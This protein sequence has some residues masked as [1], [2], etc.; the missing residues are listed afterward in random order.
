MN[1]AAAL[2]SDTTGPGWRWLMGCGFVVLLAHFLLLQVGMDF[3]PGS[4]AP[5]VVKLNSRLIEAAPLRSAAQSAQSSYKVPQKQAVRAPVSPPPA[6]NPNAATSTAF[7]KSEDAQAS[8]NSLTN[9]PAP[10][11]QAEPTPTPTK[12]AASTPVQTALAR[13]PASGTLR[14]DVIVTKNGAPNTAKGEL[15]FENTGSEY[16]A[17]LETGNWFGKRVDSSRGRL[18]QQGLVPQRYSQKTG[19]EKAAHFLWAEDRISYS[20]NRPS[21]PLAAGAQD[22]LSVIIQLASMIGADPEAWP[23]GK[24]ISMLVASTDYAEPWT[25]KVIGP[26]NVSASGQT[27]AAIKVERL[28]SDPNAQK[29]ELWFAPALEYLPARIRLTS[30]N[31]D[32][33]DQVWRNPQ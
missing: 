33:L 4:N 3:L 18:G 19:S 8:A 31:G 23:V 25:F 7:E 28:Q 11:A 12:P 32:Y 26:D 13:I 21:T 1:T 15:R 17:V 9:T 10:P 16:S 29:V 6:V 24:S 27:V 5:P 14:F 30:S 22:R 2:S 20:S